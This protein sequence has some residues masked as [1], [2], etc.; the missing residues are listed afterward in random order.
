MDQGYD[1]KRLLVLRKL[2]RNIADLMRGELKGYLATLNPLLRP[3]NVLG[4][5]V[6]SEVKEYV[7]GAEAALKDL[8]TLYAKVA[9][10][11]PYGLPPE[12]NSPLE[13]SSTSLEITPVEYVHTA[14]AN[15]QTKTVTINSPLRWVLSYSG[16]SPK[17]LREL[18][19][20][21]VRVPQMIAE[22]LQ[23]ALM[24]QTVVF[25]QPGLGE[26]LGALRFPISSGPAPG[27]GELPLTYIS[28][29]ISTVR[30]PDEVII[31]NTEVSGMDAF[32]EVVNL[33]D[34]T[35]LRNTFREKLTE[36]V[37]EHGIEAGTHSS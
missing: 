10:A 5:H 3:R 20:E 4:E 28:S 9:S 34:I 31:E 14:Q 25:H 11:K 32:E 29:A 27:F 18:L 17:R 30:P 13:V 15:A 22:Y 8:Q 33:D 37:E 35:G 16:F 26:L 21:R 6:K 24:L 2:T 1:T 23:H 19:A 36:L 7:K 12:L